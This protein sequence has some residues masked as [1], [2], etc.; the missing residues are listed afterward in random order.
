[1]IFAT[2][3]ASGKGA[4]L[5]LAIVATLDQASRL[6]GGE[7][8]SLAHIARD[9]SRIGW[10]DLAS[11]AGPVPKRT[12]IMVRLRLATPRAHRPRPARYLPD[13]LLASAAHP[14][15]TIIALSAAVLAHSASL[16][17]PFG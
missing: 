4:A 12:I 3:R 10:S 9:R 7:T 16:G 8:F 14:F 5:N 1:M 13:A 15:T 6:A 17:V 2:S 11:T